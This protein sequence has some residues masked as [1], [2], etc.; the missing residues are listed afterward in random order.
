MKGDETDG[1]TGD[2]GDTVRTVR[3]YV[4]EVGMITVHSWSR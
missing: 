1:D 4:S 3:F 2:T